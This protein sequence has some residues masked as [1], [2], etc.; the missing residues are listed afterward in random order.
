MKVLA[1]YGSPRKNGNTALMMNEALS[2]FPSEAEIHSVFLGD[3]TFSACGSCRECKTTGYCVVN[4]D[5]QKIYKEML[6]AEIILIGSPSQFSD[7]SADVKKLMERTWWM[8]GDLR[9]K[10]GGYVITGRRYIES[11]INTLHAFF[12]RHRMILGGS[13]ALGYTFTEMG[14]LEY[15]PLALRDAKS[16]GL[17]LVELYHLIYH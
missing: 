5:M 6:W 1:I 11:T 12:L 15:D 8:K 13:G 4:D 17:R 10:I 2:A 7:V 14:T 9:N 3:L 16:T